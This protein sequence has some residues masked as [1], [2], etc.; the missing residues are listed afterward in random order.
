MLRLLLWSSLLISCQL[1][2]AASAP[3][4]ASKGILES[5]VQNA[6]FEDDW[7]R[8]QLG[9]RKRFLLL[10]TSD[11]GLAESDGFPDYWTYKRDSA[12]V[13][14]DTRRGR[15]GQRSLCLTGKAQAFQ[16]IRFAAQTSERSGGAYYAA[17]LPLE[18]GMAEQL[19]SRS[20][21]VGAWCRAQEVPEGAEPRLKLEVDCR[22]RPGAEPLPVIEQGKWSGSVAFDPGSH[23]WQYREIQVQ[24]EQLPGTPYFVKISL[25]SQGGKAWFDDVTCVEPVAPDTL[26][27]LQEGDFERQSDWDTPA[28]WSWFRTDYY[29]WAG[30][31]HAANKRPRGGVAFDPFVFW[32]GSQSLRMTALPGDSFTVAG[33]PVV[34]DQK[35]AAPI[36]VRA[37]VLGDN[38]RAF[39]IMAQDERGEWLP[40]GDF[41]GDDLET[42]ASFYDMG[43]TGLGTHPWIAV[44]KYFA[45]RRPVSHV[46]LFLCMRG[47]DGVKTGQNVVSTAW[48]D[49]LQMLARGAGSAAPPVATPRPFRAMAVDLGE[50][51]W[52]HNVLRYRVQG[53]CPRMVLKLR[54]PDGQVVTSPGLVRG[55]WLEFPYRIE[56][57]CR[58]WEEQYHAEIWAQN[59]LVQQIWLGT[60][61][62]RVEIGLKSYYPYLDEPQT[63]W[64]RLNVAQRSLTELGGL[65]LQVNG[66][67]KGACQD[68]EALD[69][70]S[71]VA[72][73]VDT[74]RLLAVEVTNQRAQAHPWSEPV[75]DQ[76]VCA[77]L[78]D[79]AGQTLETTAPARFGFVERFPAGDLPL[80]IRSTRVSARG[81]LLVNDHPYFPVYFSPHI[82]TLKE[83]NYPPRGL[84][85]TAQVQRGEPLEAAML[86]ARQD[87][88]FFQYELGEGEMNLQGPAWRLRLGKLTTAIRQIKALDPDHIVAGPRSWLVG[89][90]RHQ[91]DMK[92]FT[93][94]WDAIGVETSF[95][96]FPRVEQDRQHPCAVLAGLEAYFYQPL[97]LLRWRAYQSVIHGCAGVGLCPSGMLQARPDM[98]SFLRGLNGE[99][100][101]LGPIL[102]GGEPSDEP[103]TWPPGF[104]GLSRLHQGALYLVVARDGA[105]EGPLRLSLQVAPHWQSARVRFEARS[106]PVRQGTLID[107]F[108]HPHEVHVYELKD[109]DS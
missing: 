77:L 46:R 51:L 89:H 91:A 63:V 92:A 32:S 22:V 26:N 95:E 68:L 75:R 81:Y 82:G 35:R 90:P 69:R 48:V 107:D 71:S 109:A 72:V 93:P 3:L 1:P 64:A 62:Q 15:T 55:G 7:I 103:L 33:P 2:E 44:R 17:S 84:D 11:L 106:V 100:R 16:R 37:M 87:P 43:S 50:R 6:S 96:E 67:L 60:P 23:D 41:V 80:E 78:L 42:D 18:Q 24:P 101:G 108:A 31:S 21:A 99:F 105:R 29:A 73:E 65:Q 8:S 19:P 27:L 104:V 9:H 49:Q 36:E 39:E 34:L 47:F 5:F 30:W 94:Y 85:L 61:A 70:P 83:V 45:P 25:E 98:V 56:R 14:W 66:A 76:E 12:G 102:A 74:A 58:S 88:S 28:P 10:H 57:L 40:Q 38:L 4:P 13:S 59:R 53:S 79:Q 97:E 52:G 54:C 20:I 86:K